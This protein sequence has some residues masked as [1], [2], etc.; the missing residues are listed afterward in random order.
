MSEPLYVPA[1][2]V[3][4]CRNQQIVLSSKALDLTVTIEVSGRAGPFVRGPVS[5]NHLL[6]YIEPA[7][8]QFRA[9]LYLIDESWGSAVHD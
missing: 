7:L 8:E 9:R 2:L 5:W 3:V 6:R 4:D 1:D